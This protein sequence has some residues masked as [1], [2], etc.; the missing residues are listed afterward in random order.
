MKKILV[1]LFALVFVAFEAFATQYC[2][3]QLTNGDNH[4]YLSCTQPA[5]G[6]Y[7]IVIEADV[8][9]SGLGGSFFH[10]GSVKAQDLRN[11]ME[12]SAD[13]KTITISAS[14]DAA[15]EFYTPLYVLMPG[16]VV[17]SWPAD[18][19]WGTCGSSGSDDTEAPV[20]TAA[21][22]SE[23]THNSVVV[24][25]TATD[26]VGVTRYL[27]S[28]N[29][30]AMKSASQSPVTLNGL[31]ANTAYNLTVTAYDAAGNASVPFAMESF[32]TAELHYCS[33]PTGMNGDAEWGD[34]NGR[35]LLT[36]TKVSDNSVSVAIAPNH[37]GAVIDFF[38][39]FPNNVA[40]GAPALG[41]AGSEQPVT[42][43]LILSD[44]AS[45][46]FSINIF[47]H[48]KGMDAA[49]RWTTGVINIH[50]AELC[51][52]SGTDIRLSG[53]VSA[54]RAVKLIENG[55]LVIVRDGVRYNALGSR[56][57]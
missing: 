47:W 26:N 38:T 51:E 34:P 8:Q 14:S 55:Q 12:K 15:P 35:I 32:T 19:E 10:L 39:V 4:I 20:I 3:E 5:P 16:E 37:I 17:F 29:S 22:V 27:L 50:E 30:Q 43:A 24:T 36:V 42:D 56:V 25:V 57:P 40:A 31:T 46:D 1:S 45:L 9:M 21:T 28:N 7:V 2:H 41:E 33:F 53:A 23:I 52:A 44:L 49:G 54:G 13:G 11:Y 48:T 18:I 6:L